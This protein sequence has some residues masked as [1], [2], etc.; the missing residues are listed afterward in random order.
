MKIIT[1]SWFPDHKKNADLKCAT[2]TAYLSLVKSLTQATI[3]IAGHGEKN[4]RSPRIAEQISTLLLLS[5]S[6]SAKYTFKVKRVLLLKRLR[7]SSD[8]WKQTKIN[9]WKVIKLD[10]PFSILQA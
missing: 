1:T 8:I 2:R 4:F 5:E 3:K 10:K 6:K 7:K 9:I